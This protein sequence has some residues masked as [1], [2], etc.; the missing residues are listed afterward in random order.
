LIAGIK[1]DIEYA[2]EQL[3]NPENQQY[4]TNPY[5]QIV[6]RKDGANEHTNGNKDNN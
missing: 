1:G 2:K 5:F 3:E 4:K 6:K